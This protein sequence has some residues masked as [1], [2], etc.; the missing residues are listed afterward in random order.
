MIY[1]SDPDSKILYLMSD[2]IHGHQKV[3]F[4]LISETDNSQLE[5]IIRKA[6]TE[7]RAD[8]Q[9]TII[10]D[11]ALKTMY[12]NFRGQRSIY[13]IAEV[14]G[15]MAGGCGIAPL[16]GG[17]ENTCELQRMFL[18]KEARGLGLG[19]KLLELCLIKAK[20]FGYRLV[21]LETLSDMHAA[22]S[23]YK[24]F[25]FEKNSDPIGNTGHGGCNVYMIL[26]L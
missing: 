20:E 5:N 25:G 18:K 3:S 14:E 21:Y 19:K 6:M 10:G 4:R 7:F 24:S 2:T 15:E 13:Y 9:T 23:L 11:P 22:I 17:D 26:S 12:Q 8:P 1:L 16:A